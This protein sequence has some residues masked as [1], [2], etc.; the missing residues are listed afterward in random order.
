MNKNLLLLAAAGVGLYFL[1]NKTNASATPGY[2]SSVI[3]AWIAKMKNTPEWY[4]S[5]VD[6]AKAN[7]ITIDDQLLIDAKWVID[8]GWSLT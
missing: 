8:Q 5:E 1:Y 4:S 7:G 2:D 6:K 3:A